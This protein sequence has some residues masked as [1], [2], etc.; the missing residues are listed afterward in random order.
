MLL[1]P[2]SKHLPLGLWQQIFMCLTTCSV[3]IIRWYLEKCDSFTMPS[4]EAKMLKA[5]LHGKVRW[6]SYRLFMLL[7]YCKFTVCQHR[8]Q[9]TK[10]M[11]YLL[12]T[13]YGSAEHLV[14]VKDTFQWCITSITIC[15]M[16]WFSLCCVCKLCAAL[17]HYTEKMTFFFFFYSIFIPLSQRPGSV[18]QLSIH[19]SIHPP[20]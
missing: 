2:L 12:C 3:T 15:A 13:D 10:V 6:H 11:N 8:V 14:N 18:I 20:L 4:L 1:H 16:Y 9:R 17:E 5:K 19:P 7:M